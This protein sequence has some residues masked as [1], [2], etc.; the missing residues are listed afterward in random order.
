VSENNEPTLSEPD[1][2]S[3]I[4]NTTKRA[5]FME[6]KD[7]NGTKVYEKIV[8]VSEALP[9][10]VNRKF[11]TASDNQKVLEVKLFSQAEDGSYV[12][13][14]S[15]FFTISENLP[16]DSGIIFAFTV[17]LDEVIDLKVKPDATGKATRIVLGRGNYDTACLNELSQSIQSVLRDPNLDA[18][19][20]KNF[21]SYVQSCVDKLN[22]KRRDDLDEEWKTIKSEIIEA[23]PIMQARD[24]NEVY[25]VISQILP[26]VFGKFIKNADSIRMAELRQSYEES[27]NPAILESLKEVCHK[28]GLFIDMYLYAILG[29]RAQN[30][31]IANKAKSLF[32]EMMGYLNSGNITAIK[33]LLLENNDWLGENLKDAGGPVW[34][35]PD[36][37]IKIG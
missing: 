21:M 24:E 36:T 33:N 15:G 18:E 31:I 6:V 19:Q 1:P 11:Y 28:Y 2:S 8:D 10:S 23:K 26:D 22:S 3:L 14:T 4:F 32:S 16:K 27:K 29:N 9:L 20:K 13:D 37:D 12:F 17:D 35:G 25:L 30:A 5:V 7:A 34:D